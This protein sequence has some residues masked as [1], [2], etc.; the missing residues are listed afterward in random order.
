MSPAL[1]ADILAEQPVLEMSKRQNFNLFSA[2][3]YLYSIYTVLTT[4]DTAFT[5]H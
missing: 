3:N 1:Q 4:I 5:L 2:S